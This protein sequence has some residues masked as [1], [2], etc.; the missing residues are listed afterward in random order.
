MRTDYNEQL[1]N[2]VIALQERQ[3][4]VTKKSV[5]EEA[6]IR[7]SFYSSS[8][9]ISNE[10]RELLALEIAADAEQRQPEGIRQTATNAPDHTD[11]HQR[12]LHTARQ[13]LQ[14]TWHAIQRGERQAFASAQDFFNNL[15]DV[16]PQ[17][18]A[19]DPA[20]KDMAK[21]CI[22]PSTALQQQQQEIAYAL[23]RP[24]QSAQ[25]LSQRYMD[26]R[27]NAAGFAHLSRLV[28][29][30]EHA[31]LFANAYNPDFSKRAAIRDKHGLA[32]Q[33][34]PSDLLQANL[35]YSQQKGYPLLLEQ[36]KDNPERMLLI[37][38]TEREH[39]PKADTFRTWVVA[40]S[41][42][43]PF[44]TAHA[45]LQTLDPVYNP[46]QIITTFASDAEYAEEHNR[47]GIHPDNSPS[48]SQAY[49]IVGPDYGSA[50]QEGGEPLSIAEDTQETWV[51]HVYATRNT[52]EL[53]DAL[54]RLSGTLP[55]VGTD[56]QRLLLQHGITGQELRTA[57][58]GSS[59]EKTI[60]AL[61]P[62]AKKTLFDTVIP[63]GAYP[64]SAQQRQ[65]YATLQHHQQQV[66]AK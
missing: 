29:M 20:L 58:K 21:Q 57:I 65:M 22:R 26:E 14:E 34:K 42:K 15:Q 31:R 1:I 16:S 30:P 53:V 45:F 19:A 3:G 28:V 46:V 47:I 27:R 36:Y 52:Q 23:A 25:R 41:S 17:H 9:K 49:S 24:Q 44:R 33:Q 51:G 11:R 55:S 8:T 63:A 5:L 38:A 48:S 60:T 6:G 37:V 43:Q 12:A 66:V 40:N 10:T 18:L 2:A 7:P 13:C 32:E 62:L 50:N 4:K 39:D 56:G 59:E 61:L 35:D 64:L 54:S